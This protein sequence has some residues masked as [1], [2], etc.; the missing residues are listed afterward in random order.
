MQKLVQENGFYFKAFVLRE[1]ELYIH[2]RDFE[3]ELEYSIDYTD[4]GLRT[5]RQSARK[6]RAVQ[7]LILL[8]MSIVGLTALLAPVPSGFVLPS[9]SWSII[10]IGLL[11][12][13]YIYLHQEPAKLFLTGGQKQITFLAENTGEE[14]FD[15]FFEALTEKIKASYRDSYLR[16]EEKIS[17]DEQR[18]RIHWLKDMKVITRTERD[19]L[20]AEARNGDSIG[21]RKSA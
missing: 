1:D 11:G 4:L 3:G 12:L 19:I 15:I 6:F 14:A 2:T 8:A 16:K 9:I 17:S 7:W 20:L 13:A 21:F 5:Y 10:A 18:E